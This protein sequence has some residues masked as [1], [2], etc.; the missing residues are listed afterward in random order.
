M[1][2]VCKPRAKPRDSPLTLDGIADLLVDQLTGN[3]NDLV[4]LSQTNRTLFF[5]VPRVKPDEGKPDE[6]EPA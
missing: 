3:K 2:R 1:S 5:D 6:G 4:H